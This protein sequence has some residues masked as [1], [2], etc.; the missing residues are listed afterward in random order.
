M[1]RAWF[2]GNSGA[3]YSGDCYGLDT[4][5]LTRRLL[6]S[7]AHTRIVVAQSFFDWPR[8]NIGGLTT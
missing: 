3:G 5:T 2:L 8:P 1:V 6:S 4:V 7:C